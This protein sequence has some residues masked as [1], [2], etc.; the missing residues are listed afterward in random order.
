MYFTIAM[1]SF[2][3]TKRKYQTI[4]N[5]TIVSHFSTG[6]CSDTRTGQ[7]LGET[8][9]NDGPHQVQFHRGDVVSGLQ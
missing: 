7:R 1:L 8:G 5:G 4:K 3:L 6:L 9:R 2:L